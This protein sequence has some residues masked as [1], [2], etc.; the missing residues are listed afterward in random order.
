[1]ILAESSHSAA[2]FSEGKKDFD[3]TEHLSEKDVVD[4]LEV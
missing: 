1:M 2:V 4:F 3:E